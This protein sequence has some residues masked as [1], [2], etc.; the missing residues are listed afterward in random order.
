MLFAKLSYVLGRIYGMPFGLNFEVYTSK[1]IKST[2]C[3]KLCCHATLMSRRTRPQNLTAKGFKLKKFNEHAYLINI[4]VY[5]HAREHTMNV[6]FVV[7]YLVHRIWLPL[8]TNAELTTKH[9]T[10]YWEAAFDN[11]FAIGFILHEKFVFHFAFC[12]WPCL[13]FF[14]ARCYGAILK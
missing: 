5:T 4:Y 8:W 2:T 7:A 13:D 14:I 12:L 11:I 6:P 9:V 1:C 10:I 3:G